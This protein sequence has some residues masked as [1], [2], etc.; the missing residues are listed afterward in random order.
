M[1]AEAHPPNAVR[2]QDTTFD[3]EG[4]IA[5]TRNMLFT[6]FT[7]LDPTITY[8]D[9]N[10]HFDGTIYETLRIRFTREDTARMHDCQSRTS[11]ARS[12]GSRHRA[13]WAVEPAP[14]NC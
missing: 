10:A 3:F 5:D 8:E 13:Y 6:L 2:P 11:L 4:A 7:A 9:F 12:G 1:K 14:C